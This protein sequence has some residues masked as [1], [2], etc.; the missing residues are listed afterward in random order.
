M[1]W[2]LSQLVHRYALAVD[3]GR[4]AGDLFTEDGV[5]V[6]PDLPD[7]FEPA[8]AHEGRAAVQAATTGLP[9]TFHAVVGEVYAGTTGRIACV[10]HHLVAPDKD[11]VWHLRYR[12]DY[13]QV[14]GVWLFARRELTIEFTETR[15][16]KRSRI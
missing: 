6:V 4:G 11:A 14:G 12:D 2:E 9:R 16:L 13:R 7:G 3:E 5:L 1:S 10:A 15:A 8:V